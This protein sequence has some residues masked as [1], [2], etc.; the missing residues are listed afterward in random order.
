MADATALVDRSVI[1]V[2][3]KGDGKNQEVTC[4]SASVAWFHW[5]DRHSECSGFI[6]NKDGEIIQHLVAKRIPPH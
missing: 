5:L 4:A 2:V 1:L 3:E 6:R